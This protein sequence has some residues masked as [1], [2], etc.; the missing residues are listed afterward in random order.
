MIVITVVFFGAI[1]NN[2]TI[3]NL[4]ITNSTIIG[5]GS[6]SGGLA[7]YSCG[8]INK[9]LYSGKVSST[10]QCVGALLGGNWGTVNNCFTIGDVSGQGYI[11]GLVG[12]NANI[13]SNS[14]SS[15]SVNG[16]NI[17]GISG[18][19]NNQVNS[20]WNIDLCRN[21]QNDG[22]GLSNVEM[23]DINTFLDASWDFNAETENGTE[24]IWH[25]PYN[26]TGYPM[27]YWQRDIPGDLTGSYGINL[28]DFSELSN[29]WLDRYD[30]ADLQTLTANWLSGN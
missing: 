16:D 22:A 11:G 9:C 19:G 24:D 13:I 5:Y 15:C 25:M 6:Y 23:Q 26:A 14:Y 8:E 29:D 3:T 12:N 7:G 18:Y 10:H 30:L 28:S 27:L 21:I 4:G 17:G 1:G 20:F 2:G